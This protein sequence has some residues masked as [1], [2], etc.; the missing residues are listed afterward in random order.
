MLEANNIL[1]DE[2]YVAT[3][4]EVSNAIYKYSL[5]SKGALQKIKNIYEN[6]DDDLKNNNEIKKIFYFLEYCENNLNGFFQDEQLFFKELKNLR[7][8]YLSKIS[9][10]IYN[11]LS[12]NKMNLRN[13][14]IYNSPD[15]RI[16]FWNKKRFREEQFNKLSKLLIS[17]S[18]YNN[19]IEFYS[20]E[21]QENYLSLIKILF[22][23]MKKLVQNFSS[24]D[25]SNLNDSMNIN[26]QTIER[27]RKELQ[28]Y[29]KKLNQCQHINKELQNYNK[30][31]EQIVTNNNNIEINDISQTEQ[32]NNN[33]KNTVKM[34]RYKSSQ[35]DK[36]IK[37]LEKQNNLLFKKNKDNQNE[38]F[39]RDNKYAELLEQ[40]QLY[41][42]KLIEANRQINEKKEII[43]DI[44]KENLLMNNYNNTINSNNN[45]ESNNNNLDI[46]FKEKN[47]LDE[48]NKKL[49]NENQEKDRNY[50]ILEKKYNELKEQL[51]DKQN[52][53]Q[54]DAH[55]NDNDNDNGNNKE[56]YEEEIKSLKNNISLLEKKLVNTENELKQKYI[57][58]LKLNNELE[59][60][61]TIT[62]EEKNNYSQNI[63]N[64]NEKNS[65]I[66]NELKNEIKIKQELIDKLKE[67]KNNDSKKN[68]ELISN[69]NNDNQKLINNL[70][71]EIENKVKIINDLKNEI[72]EAN[73]NISKL[74][75]L[76]NEKENT[77]KEIKS[78]N[79]K[80]KNENEN[81]KKIIDNLTSEKNNLLKSLESKEKELKEVQKDLKEKDKDLK[82]VQKILKE[83]QNNLT[84]K[85]KNYNLLLNENNEYKS[86][87][88]EEKEKNIKLEE[89][90]AKNTENIEKMNLQA[91]QIGHFIE[92]INEKDELIKNIKTCLNNNNSGNL[93]EQIQREIQELREANKKLIDENNNLK[94]SNVFLLQSTN[95]QLI[96]NA[97]INELNE[98]KDKV[99]ELQ[100]EN[101]LL[102][103]QNDDLLK[104]S[105]MAAPLT[106]SV[107]ILTEEE[108]KRKDLQIEKLQKEL[109]DLKKNE[110]ILMN[111]K[112]NGKESLKILSQSNDFEE[113]FNN[114]DLANIAR[115]R[116]DSEDKKIDF[117]G[118]DG[119]KEKYDDCIKK[120][121]ELK[122]LIGYIISRSQCDDPD[123]QQ[124]AKRACEILE[125]DIE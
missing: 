15:Y 34:E 68:N 48:Q 95:P 20:D 69:L 65:K 113:E 21:D 124:K 9:N 14:R 119:L 18:N 28:N 79:D 52:N 122:E 118:L 49:K 97:S 71:K 91:S 24:D 76:L 88:K 83:V 11:I 8:E 47:D 38:I 30:Y 13:R 86:Q 46:L 32:L 85:E 36:K 100:E 115:E 105:T 90:K 101:F 63:L 16:N 73:S 123:L 17:L 3:I 120:K 2:E 44:Q 92:T 99:K 40:V 12:E 60:L 70:K 55:D 45:V 31:L 87:L 114:F 4:N 53:N 25:D 125:I 22:E 98:Y 42:N 59:E 33:L 84:E 7:K 54:F 81:T 75:S 74:K 89:L 35:K 56:K 29:K 64:I 61:K 106:N 6:M 66:I 96:N 107:N 62:N 112:K 67:E 103:S 26:I 111:N 109:N 80:N 77:I 93:N 50:K 10:Y 116:N 104:K 72:N 94:Q 117:P 23:E 121:E 51:N 57:D 1:R 27:N 39:Q 19:K 5:A 41:K 37:E 110:N 58:Y 43:K 108:N 102:K 82:E 78:N